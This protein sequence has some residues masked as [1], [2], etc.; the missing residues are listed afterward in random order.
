MVSTNW[1][2]SP[3]TG[4]EL[5]V[6]THWHGLTTGAA[7]SRW[8]TLLHYSGCPMWTLV[9]W[10]WP[11][12][13]L[14]NGLYITLYSSNG[15]CIF[16]VWVE[17]GGFGFPLSTSSTHCSQCIWITWL[18]DWWWSLIW[19]LVHQFKQAVCMG[20][21]INLDN[22]NIHLWRS[23]HKKVQYIGVSIYHA[24]MEDGRHTRDS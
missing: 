9:N 6:P 3:H 18:L 2:W 20:T 15:S 10:T 1:Q 11:S 21:R 7:F 19:T 23:G 24:D 13:V 5:L 16:W 14:G 12:W 8:A 17:G 22:A 4:H